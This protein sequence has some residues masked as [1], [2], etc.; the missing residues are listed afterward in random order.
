MLDSPKENVSENGLFLSVRYG[1][2]HYLRRNPVHCKGYFFEQLYGCA[3]LC[4]WA[5]ETKQKTI[6]SMKFDSGVRK[7]KME[8]IE[9][10]YF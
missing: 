6:I 10:K 1:T 2:D 9:Q 8:K 5:S 4:T 7:N 3:H